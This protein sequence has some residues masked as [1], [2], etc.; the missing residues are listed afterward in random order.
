MSHSYS[1]S[2]RS[3]SPL[4]LGLLVALPMLAAILLAPGLA[5]ARPPAT[6]LPSGFYEEQIVGGLRLPTSFAVAPDGRIFITEKKGLVRVA[7]DGELLPDPFIDLTS[8][9]ND[10]ADRGL[11]SVAVHPKWPAQ[12]Y[13]YL[14]YTFEPDEAKAYSRTGARVARVLRLEAD[15]ANLNVHKPGSGFVLVGSN[16]TFEHIGNPDQGDTEPFSCFESGT[17]REGASGPFIRDC[18]ATEGTAH[19]VDFLKFGRDGSLFVSVGDGIV[20]GW[21]NWRAQDPDSLNGKIL[22]VDPMTG[23]GYSSNPFAEDDLTAN[24]AKVYA[25]GMRNPFRFAFVPAT[26]ELMVGDVGNSDYEEIN[27][28]GPASN[29]GWPCFEGREQRTDFT[30]C[31]PLHSGD[32]AVT[33]AIHLYPHEATPPR[34][35]VIGGDFYTG[36]LYPAEYRGVYFYSD[37]NGGVIWA[38][39]LR[40]DGG[41]SIKEFATSAP[42]PIQLTMGPD[43]NLWML[44]IA[45]GE[46]V[47]LA[48]SGSA[49]GAA[50]P[51]RAATATPAARATTAATTTAATTTAATTTAATTTAAADSDTLTTTQEAAGATATPAP[52]ATP[53]AEPAG[54]EA[55]A[56]AS[57]GAGA[58]SITR[59]IWTPLE[60]IDV[61]D[62]TGA[63]AYPDNPTKRETITSFDAP[64]AG[65]KDYGQ[66]IR[67]YIH[68]P[69]SGSYR[70]WL[71]SDDASI[72]LLST[73]ESPANA[74]GI[75]SVSGWT[76]YQVWDKYVTQGS[77]P[78][79]LEA[80]KRY[81]IEVLHKQGDQKENLSVAW[82]PPGGAREIIGGEFLSPL[83]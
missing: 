71:A 8:E 25:L 12:P 7:V 19:T 5:Q 9:V 22:R 35:S 72:L 42:G 51:S 29:F 68:P 65:N 66:R 64:R 53:A 37:F 13:I 34:G 32:A 33:H 47:R 16:S 74:V 73:D 80:G 14:A 26:G 11:M 56:S 24:R 78:I 61:E 28:G 1:R 67:G 82:Q 3:R 79:E 48:Y 27:R 6:A 20:N 38:M 62:L 44:Y 57:A 15:S 70:F 30:I 39:T 59:E 2:R 69:V 77:A 63:D 54:T 21:G 58:G 49:A 81:Y 23:N 43:G 83:D 18:I 52:A 60:G 40:R 41:A 50:G 17:G 76:P 31:D 45:T 36:R 75:A 10:S 4:L 55:T 46:V